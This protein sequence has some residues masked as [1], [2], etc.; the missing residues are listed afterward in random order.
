ML[1][2]SLQLRL[3]QSL[4]ITPQL[5]QA[6][7]LLQ[8]SSLELQTEIQDI[9]ESNPL[10]EKDEDFDTEDNTDA[11]DT[12]NTETEVDG[13][14]Q[15]LTEELPIDSNW[16]DIYPESSVYRESN[17]EPAPDIYANESGAGESLKQH[18]SDQIN[19]IHLSETDR[20][21]AYILID[22]I[23]ADGYLCDSIE[24]IYQETIES[25]P[26]L[27]LDELISVLHLIQQLD[28]VGSGSRNLSECLDLQLQQLD[29]DTPLLDVTR[30]LVQHHID[31]LGKRDMRFL[32]RKL[33]ITN[34]QL[35]LVI[36]LIQSLNPRP[37]AQIS[38][39][40]PDYVV[41]DVSVIRT[42]SSWRIELN[43]DISPKLK[44]NQ[45]YAELAGNKENSEANGYIRKHLQEARWFIKSL[46]NRNETLLRVATAI[47]DHQRPF[48]DQGPEAMIPMVLRDIADDLELHESTVS[49]VTT[50]KYMHT[51]R[52]VFEFKYFFSSHVGT[53]SG[54]VCSATAIQ[55][56]IKKLIGEE[57]HSKPLSDNKISKILEEKGINV[58]RRTVA[59]YR[60]GLHIPPSS[61]RKSL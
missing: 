53:S 31:A 1:K 37:G 18:L 39:V 47:V 33:D 35:E 30:R 20:A 61:S 26:E 5:Q 11:K 17:S 54:G 12:D 60:E 56:M 45:A 52:G 50:N 15:T 57:S 28:P 42:A 7:R 9:F 4:S 29:K 43:S 3:G 34:E 21:V 48:F 25:L 10:L 8:L 55:A 14:Q 36:N 38:N 24:S 46:Q 6:I 40:R 27:E 19:L 23:D 16:E 13:E 59:K 2:P 49:R 44:I 58:A 51:P 41:P 22:E 32:Q